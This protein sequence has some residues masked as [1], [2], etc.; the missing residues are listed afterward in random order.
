MSAKSNRKKGKKAKEALAAV[1]EE[2]A[3]KLKTLE[4]SYQSSLKELQDNTDGGNDGSAPEDAEATTVS[5]SATTQQQG[6]TNNNDD[7]DDID[8]GLSA[9][10]RKQAKA[11]RKKERQKEREL[12]RQK[13][14]EEEMKNA[15]PSMKKIETDNLIKILDPLNLKIN[16]VD[17]DGHCL[18]RAIGAHAKKSYQEIRK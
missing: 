3:N 16:D 10:E 17:A 12:Q 1:E 7:N 13:E 8:A 4:E 11:R 6:T 15:G 9:K 2:Y 18:Y 14:L 5:E